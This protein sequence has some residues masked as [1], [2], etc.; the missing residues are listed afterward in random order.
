MIYFLVMTTVLNDELA[1]PSETFDVVDEALSWCFL[2][3]LL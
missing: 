2:Q 1:P 3:T